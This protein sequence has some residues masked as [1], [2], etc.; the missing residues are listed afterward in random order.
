MVLVHAHGRHI[1]SSKPNLSCSKICSEISIFR[2]LTIS[3][4]KLNVEVSGGNLTVAFLICCVY[5]T[6]AGSFKVQ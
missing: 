6:F 1:Y 4:F 3:I 5:F 2:V